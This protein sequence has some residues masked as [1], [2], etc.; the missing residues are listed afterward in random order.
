VYEVKGNINELDQVNENPME[1]D[2]TKFKLN[3]DKREKIKSI[4]PNYCFYDQEEIKGKI[5][6]KNDIQRLVPFKIRSQSK[7][8]FIETPFQREKLKIINFL[9]RIFENLELETFVPTNRAEVNF[10]CH[11]ANFTSFKVFIDNEIV[12]SN[13]TDKDL[14]EG[15]MKDMELI[16]V[17]LNMDINNENVT[18]YYYGNAIQFP[19]YEQ[20]KDIE[21][22]IQVFENTM[23]T[24]SK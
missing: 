18:F 4:I 16:E 5:E 14:C 2:E 7:L 12:R 23:M 15:L 6:I 21:G 1:I 17:T 8:L 10:I 9:D 20:D 22:V 13:E 3:L 11:T 19:S 24:P